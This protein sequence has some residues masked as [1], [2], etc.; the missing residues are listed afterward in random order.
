MEEKKY[1]I[2]PVTVEAGP[3]YK[4][5]ASYKESNPSGGYSAITDVEFTFDTEEEATQFTRALLEKEGVRED[6][7]IKE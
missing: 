4:W 6:Q 2:A 3:T 1:M 7:I 5:R